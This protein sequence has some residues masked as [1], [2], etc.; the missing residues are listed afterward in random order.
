[1]QALKR[2][3]DGCAFGD[4]TKAAYANALFLRHLIPFAASRACW[5]R[6]LLK[7]GFTFNV[8]PP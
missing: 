4:K 6:A 3:S 2:G 7:H 5:V 8:K 1:V